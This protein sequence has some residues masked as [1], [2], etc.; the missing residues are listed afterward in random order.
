MWFDYFRLCF[1]VSSVIHFVITLKEI[2]HYSMLAK[3]MWNISNAGFFLFFYCFSWTHV[4]SIAFMSA[5]SRSR[6]YDQEK[7]ISR[8]GQII[9]LKYSCYAFIL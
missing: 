4:N 3:P 8:Y 6:I 5:R 2:N 1:F 9:V 7:G